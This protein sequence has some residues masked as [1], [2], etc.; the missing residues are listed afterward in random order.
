MKIELKDVGTTT[1]TFK[2]NGNTT[3]TVMNVIVTS[4]VV[5]NPYPHIIQEI[6]PPFIM[7]KMETDL[8]KQY[9]IDQAVNFVLTKYPDVP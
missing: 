5:G 9:I 4:G 1:A 2:D 6:M 7:P 8:V 3:V